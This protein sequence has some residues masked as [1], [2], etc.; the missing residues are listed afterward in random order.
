MGLYWC[1]FP[2]WIEEAERIEAERSLR[3]IHIQHGNESTLKDLQRGLARIIGGAE[4]SKPK[5]YEQHLL[6]E[7]I[8]RGDE[9]EAEEIRATIRA[10]E[11]M[12]AHRCQKKQE[13]ST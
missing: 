4:V 13:Q 12:E 1:E 11:L 8:R 3:A 7:A 9:A 2:L 5:S 6:E 10:Q